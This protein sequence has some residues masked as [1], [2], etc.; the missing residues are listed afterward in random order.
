MEE[1]QQ[2]PQQQPNQ[3]PQPHWNQPQ[4]P[5]YHYQPNPY[6]EANSKKILA[7]ILALFLGHLGIHKFVLGYNNEGIILLVLGLIGYATACLLVGYIILFVTGII[8]LVEG[9]IYLTKSDQDFYH[10]Y[11]QH[12]KPWF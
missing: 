12:K 5:Q 11:I 1:N 10:T 6:Q 7:G 4:Q 2:P 3:N 9:I 8:G